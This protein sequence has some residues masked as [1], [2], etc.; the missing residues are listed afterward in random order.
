MKKIKVKFISNYRQKEGFAFVEV[1][2][3]YPKSGY[4]NRRQFKRLNDKLCYNSTDFIKLMDN[5]IKEV[6]VMNKNDSCIDFIY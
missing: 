6:I 4:I 1:N 2:K 3:K 5:R